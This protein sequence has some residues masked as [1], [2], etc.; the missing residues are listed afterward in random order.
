MIITVDGDDWLNNKNVLKIIKNVYKKHNC[1]LTYGNYVKHPMNGYRRLGSY[2][3]AIIRAN[4][5][6][7]KGWIASHPRTF[8]YVL[9]K[10]I[11]RADLLD[12]SGNFYRMAWDL[13][14]MFP[15]LE[16]SGGRFVNID[17]PL[18]VYNDANPLND[19]KINKKYQ[20][21]L[22]KQI[23]KKK[24]YTVLKISSIK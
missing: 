20:D 15:M 13:A 10:N 14:M 19:H 5:Y 3:P 1:L 12:T 7:H 8:K 21:Q 18:Y 2:P 22:N 23:R 24:K 11:K 17:K 16:M 9:W 4:R 6:R